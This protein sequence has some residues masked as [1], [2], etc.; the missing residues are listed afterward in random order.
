[1][2]SEMKGNKEAAL[3]DYKQANGMSPDYPEAKEALIRL[4]QKPQ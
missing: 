1:M 3:A 4:G 2:C